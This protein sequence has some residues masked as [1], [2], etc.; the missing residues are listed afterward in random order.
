M[1]SRLVIQVFTG[2]LSE[3]HCSSWP[4][5]VFKPSSFLFSQSIQAVRGA[6]LEWSSQALQL[7]ENDLCYPRVTS[8]FFISL[9]LI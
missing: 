6:H 4:L 8:P 2:N 1:R 5:M 3:P 9:E 7:V